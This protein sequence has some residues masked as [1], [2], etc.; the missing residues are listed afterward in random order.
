M[1]NNIQTLSTSRKTLLILGLFNKKY[2]FR[3]KVILLGQILSGFAENLSLLSLLPLIGLL[4]ENQISNT[5]VGLYFE[6]FYNFIGIT[7]SLNNI[8]ILIVTLL[9]FRAVFTI[10][11][12]VIRQYCILSIGTEKRLDLVNA[13]FLADWSFYT[14]KKLGFYSNLLSEES[15]KIPTTYSS[16]L[17]FLTRIIEF[18]IYLCTAIF[19]S[20]HITFISLAL[21]VILLLILTPLIN[22]GKETGIKQVY[23]RNTISNYLIEALQGIK[24]IKSTAKIHHVTNLLKK[25]IIELLSIQKKQQK[26]IVTLNNLHEP[27]IAIVAAIILFISVN[28]LKVDVASIAVMTVLFTRMIRQMA[29]IQSNYNLIG[30]NLGSL[31]LFEDFVEEIRSNSEK[32]KDGKKLLFNNEIKF[33]NVGISY[34][35][36][37]ILNKIN[38]SLNKNSLTIIYGPSGGGKTSIVD[39]LIGFKT[40]SNG[41]ILIDNNKLTNM[42][43]DYWRNQ[44]GYVPQEVFLFDDTIYENIVLGDNSIKKD[45]VIS[46]LKKSGAWSFVSK[47]PKKLQT[48]VGPNGMQMSGGQRQRLSIARALFK[49][50]RLIILDEATSSLDKTTEKKIC[51]TIKELSLKTTILCITHNDQLLKFADQKFILDKKQLKRK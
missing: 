34:G 10:I 25:K 28:H 5:K 42:D 2:P 48:K 20:L 40:L 47:L 12:N 45:R 3:F 6:E 1:I 44:I 15:A 31:V 37:I 18:A 14:K 35:K 4:L 27:L 17:G 29:K 38:F 36:K 24:V 21:G 30:V 16:A 41:K 8:L 22:I 19:L 26:S 43:L 49:E 46:T 50:P 7:L 23:V 11:I 13:L 39:A 51:E 33:K 9:I 32:K